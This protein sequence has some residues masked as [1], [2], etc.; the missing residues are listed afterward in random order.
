MVEK[1]SF[2]K[3][4]IHALIM[5]FFIGYSR[6]MMAQRSISMNNGGSYNGVG[7]MDNGYNRSMSFNGKWK[8]LLF[9]AQYFFAAMLPIF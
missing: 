6:D 5:M 9:Q 2:F 7:G 1:F 8:R 4:N 3:L